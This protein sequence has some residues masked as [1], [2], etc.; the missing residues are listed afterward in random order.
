MP[1]MEGAGKL[2][3]V[4]LRTLG[5]GDLLTGVP[6][7]RALREA[8]PDADITLAAPSV[9]TPIAALSGAVDGVADTAP[10]TPLHP[11]LH[12]ADLAVDLDGRV[13]ESTRLLLA[14]RPGRLIGFAHPAV[15]ATRGLPRWTPDEHEVIRWCRLLTECGI[16]AD[17]GRLRLPP[18][19]VPSPAPGA[20]IVHPGA[21]SAARR[22]PAGR[23]AA[24][25][26][27]LRADRLRVVVTGSPD[28]RG[29]AEEVATEAG[30]SSYSVLAGRTG[31]TTLAA[32]T[33][34]AGLVLSGDTG[35]A[36]LAAAYE[37]PAVT[38]A[39]PVPPRLGGPPRRP[40]HAVLWAG[41]DGDPQG[42]KPDPGLLELTVADV[43][44]AVRE[45]RVRRPRRDGGGLNHGKPGS[46]K[47]RGRAPA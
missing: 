1:L 30:L 26:R 22:W 23:W 19:T 4:V 36:H 2:S 25:A 6:A 24:V 8:Y 44:A 16:P 3:V 10:L 42:D 29:L 17:P 35:I 9:L 47:Q 27:Q 33:A 34:E 41:H 28:E 32:L 45:V 13:P 14:T 12:G 15:P 40:W 38:L 43:M 46:A 39:G 20:V 11:G 21:S 31:L 7:L 5:L 37:R 18:P